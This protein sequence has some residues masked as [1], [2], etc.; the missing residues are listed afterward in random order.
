VALDFK[1]L[2][3]LIDPDADGALNEQVDQLLRKVRQRQNE[4]GV[5]DTRATLL[6][7]RL[8]DLRSAATP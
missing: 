1:N 2:L 3:R 5:T 6:R 8:N 4:G 7:E